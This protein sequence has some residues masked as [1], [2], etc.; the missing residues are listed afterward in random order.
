MSGESISH[1]R[2]LERIG[3]GGMGEVYRAYDDRLKRHVAIK[4]LPADSS[5]SASIKLRHLVALTPSASADL[6]ILLSHINRYGRPC[7]AH[8]CEPL[9]RPPAGGTGHTE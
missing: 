3:A 8:R 5:A 4:I 1:Y 2:I 9:K 6:E 7:L